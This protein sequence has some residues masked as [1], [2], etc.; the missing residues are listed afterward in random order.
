[1][2]FN[3]PF[4]PAGQNYQSFW[5]MPSGSQAG[6]PATPAAPTAPTT[7][8]AHVGTT[9]HPNA[10]GT[11]QF[12]NASPS[13]TAT[14]TQSPLA[15]ATAAPPP[16]T[17]SV[18]QSPVAPAPSNIWTDPAALDA[19]KA[20]HPAPTP[21]AAPRNPL[22]DMPLSQM[23]QGRQPNNPNAVAQNEQ[24]WS[25]RLAGIT[26]PAQ[27]NDA[28]LGHYGNDLN[29][30]LRLNDADYAGMIQ[31]ANQKI[32]DLTQTLG[33]PA[34]AQSAPQYQEYIAQQQAL[35]ENIKKA[36]ALKAAI[37]PYMQYLPMAGPGQID[38]AYMNANPTWAEGL[39][40]EVKSA[41]YAA[42]IGQYAKGIQGG[43]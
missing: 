26:D 15:G 32:A 18:S 2:T 25:S 7:P 28:M 22:L 37:G 10:V 36:Q 33:D 1:M 42:G 20:S 21:T 38:W 27:R 23:T 41:L 3:R 29:N 4:R 5:G 12:P 8:Y 39:P 40:P 34:F 9:M 24:A 19:Y 30:L 11:T 13:P 35:I 17:P 43:Y 6:T 31:S 16:A 14:P